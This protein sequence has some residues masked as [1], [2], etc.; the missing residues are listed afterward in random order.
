MITAITVL[1]PGPTLLGTEV[2][3]LCEGGV[4]QPPV[5]VNV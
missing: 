1:F 3:H 4:T 5:L 2:P